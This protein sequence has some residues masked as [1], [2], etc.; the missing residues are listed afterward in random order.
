VGPSEL[1]VDVI[2]L[3]SM[4]SVRRLSRGATGD[5]YARQTKA[6]QQPC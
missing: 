3:I 6:K 1:L 4:T 2:V 5:A